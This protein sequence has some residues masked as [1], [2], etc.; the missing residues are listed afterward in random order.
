ME[1]T[2][3]PHLAGNREVSSQKTRELATDGQPEARASHPSPGRSLLEGIENPLTVGGGNPRSTVVHID[4]EAG[5]ESIAGLDPHAPQDVPL[6][7][8][9]DGV[10]QQI[11]E[12]LT[13]LPLVRHHAVGTSSGTSTSNATA[14]SRCAGGTCQS[15]QP[16]RPAG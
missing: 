13:Q 11:D 6:L 16:P 10:A 9:L 8:E 7:G 4:Q 2:A 14:C 1:A 15:S 3:P 12:D 5:C